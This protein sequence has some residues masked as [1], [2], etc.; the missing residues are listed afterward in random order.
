M[1]KSPSR[2]CPG[3][4]PRR[5]NCSNLIS[6]SQRCCVEC[7]PYDK[8]SMKEYDR[9][10]GSSAERG[11]DRRWRKVR[12]IKLSIDPLCE[13]CLDQGLTTKATMVHHIKPIKTHP[14]LRLVL[15]NLQ[16]LCNEHHEELEKEGRWGN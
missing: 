6:G 15:T 12:E 3:R 16:S 8:N 9:K 4:G 1:P 11:Y 7:L 5:A 10:R 2:P 14:E 13:V